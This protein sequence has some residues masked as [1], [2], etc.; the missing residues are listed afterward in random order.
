MR[1]ILGLVLGLVLGWRPGVGL[2]V[3]HR[4]DPGVGPCVDVVRLPK[5]EV[6]LHVPA[7]SLSN[8]AL[9]N[10]SPLFTS[11]SKLASVNVYDILLCAVVSSRSVAVTAP[12]TVPTGSSSSAE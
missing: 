10:T 1:L 6:N 4:V 9:M 3:G 5:S 2:G 11:T 7:A 12:T 8:K